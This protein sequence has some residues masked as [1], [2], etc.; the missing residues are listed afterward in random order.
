MKVDVLLINP[1]TTWDDIDIII[2]NIGLGYLAEALRR[3]GTSVEIG[4]YSQE[5]DLQLNEKHTVLQ[6]VHSISPAR[7]EREIRSYLGRYLFTGDDVMKPI[8]VLSGG[9]ISRLALAGILIKPT[10]FLILD[11]PTNHLDIFSRDV[12]QEALK[13]YSG[14]LVLI[15]HDEKLLS[16][17]SE[18]LFVVKNEKVKEFA[19]NFAEYVDKLRLIADQ[20]FKKP[21]MKAQQET[22]REFDKERKRREAAERNRVYKERR[23]VEKRVERIEKK[24]VPLETRRKEIETLFC[25]QEVVNNSNMLVELQKEHSYLS[26]EITAL[27]EQWMEIAG[28]E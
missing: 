9:E 2:P 7:S 6:H 11:E 21:E 8:P 20:Q 28:E 18:K 23:K 26:D 19:G 5:I 13:N 4:Y 14:T 17:L 1:V 16:A 22:G 3:R 25:Q 15:S 24:M 10:N 27:E 12:L